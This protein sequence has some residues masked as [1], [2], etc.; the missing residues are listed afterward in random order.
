MRCLFPVHQV[1]PVKLRFRLWNLHHRVSGP[2]G[3]GTGPEGVEID[4]VDQ[5]NL[6]R[7]SGDKYIYIYSHEV[8]Y[9][10]IYS[11]K[12][13]IFHRLPIKNGGFSIDFHCFFDVYQRRLGGC[14]AMMVTHDRD[15]RVLYSLAINYIVDK[16]RYIYISI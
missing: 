1:L 16:Y 8:I 3:A 12:R 4:R 10:Y 2:R 7:T 9:I 5:R 11:Y 14:L 13:M 6:A 15:T